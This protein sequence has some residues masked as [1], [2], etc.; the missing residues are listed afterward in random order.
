MQAVSLAS[1]SRSDC[2]PKRAQFTASVA[3]NLVVETPLKVAERRIDLLVLI[4]PEHLSHLLT[5]MWHA[6]VTPAG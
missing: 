5:E 3:L 1:R 6:I 2:L 4:F